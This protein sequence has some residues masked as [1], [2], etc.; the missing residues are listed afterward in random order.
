MELRTNEPFRWT[1][2]EGA[3]GL[4]LAQRGLESWEKGCWVELENLDS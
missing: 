4:Q 2:L 1:L 3:K